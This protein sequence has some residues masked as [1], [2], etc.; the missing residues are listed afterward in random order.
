MKRNFSQKA[1]IYC[2]ARFDSGFSFCCYTICLQHK[3][4]YLV[5]FRFCTDFGHVLQ[6]EIQNRFVC[7]VPPSLSLSL[8]EKA[9]HKYVANFCIRIRNVCLQSHSSI[10]VSARESET[11]TESE[12]DSVCAGECVFNNIIQHSP[13]KSPKRMHGFCQRKLI[14]AHRYITK[15]Y[16]KTCNQNACVCVCVCICPEW[17]ERSCS[18]RVWGVPFTATKCAVSSA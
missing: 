12:C 10:Y 3:Q 4:I 11:E 2:R 7:C 17:S 1:S 15:R 5:V 9:S 16:A 8:C 14:H 6:A 18:S 13:V